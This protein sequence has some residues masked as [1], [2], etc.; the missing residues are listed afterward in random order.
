MHRG[1]S[2]PNAVGI[3]WDSTTRPRGLAHKKS[4]DCKGMP[5]SV[6]VKRLVMSVGPTK[7]RRSAE[8]FEL[9]GQE[10]H[11]IRTKCGG[12]RPE[13]RRVFFGDRQRRP[14]HL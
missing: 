10:H 12:V 7:R 8:S 2:S 13:N 11:T 4:P 5:T 14:G 1:L 9:A 3:R 6:E